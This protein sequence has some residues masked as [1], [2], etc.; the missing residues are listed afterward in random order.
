MINHSSNKSRFLHGAAVKSLRILKE[1]AEAIPKTMV[2]ILP[3]LVSGNGVYHFDKVTKS[4]TVGDMLA[5]VDDS[6]AGEVVAALVEPILDI[7]DEDEKE[8]ESR[9]QTFGDYTLSMIRSVNISDDS[10]VAWLGAVGLPTLAKLA[11][12]ND[13]ECTPSLTDKSRTLIKNRL[14]SAFAHLMSSPNGFMYPC[15][16]LQNLDPSAVPMDGAITS[17]KDKA[18]STMTKLLKKSKKAGDKEK[19]SLQ[20]LAL[21]YSLVIFQLY[22]GEADALTVLD[23]LKLCYDKLVRG[24]QNDDSDVDASE[25]L[26]EIL[27]SFM[28]KPSVL[29]RR[30]GQQVFEAFSSDIN[31]EGLRLMTDVLE[32]KESMQGQQELFDQEDEDMEDAGEG[33]VSD[34]EEL[35]SDVEI[36]DVGANGDADFDEEDGGEEDDEEEDQDEDEDEDEDSAAEQDEE[37]RKLEEALAKAYGAPTEDDSDDDADM[38]DSEMFEKDKLIENFLSQRKKSTSKK[39]EKKDARENI[40]NFKSRV[41]DLLEI[42]VKKQTTNPAALEILI[43]LLI[44]MRTTTS[45]DVGK[46]S[47]GVISSFAQAYRKTKESSASDSASEI[48]GRLE[49]LKTIHEEAS[50]NPAQTYAKAAATASLLVATSLVR[51]EQTKELL[52]VHN[53]VRDRWVLREIKVHPAFFSEW[54]NWFQSLASG[55]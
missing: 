49:L 25:V 43:P 14:T 6:V 23:E 54:N 17:I 55:S 36:I 44:T 46:K 50:K 45:G 30:A 52:G 4:K 21:L 28:A 33:P 35:D 31:S 16:L 10:E 39:Q 42:Y 5:N 48:T 24:K 7:D 37:T 29:L 27:L 22:N 51:A 8:V 38:T 18:I 11:Y 9:R 1:V 20:T 40:V 41:L 12:T 34:V 13:Y 15:N 2:T 3:N 19:R 53:A 32:S 47:H 26:V